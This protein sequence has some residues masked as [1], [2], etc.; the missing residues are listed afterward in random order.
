[1]NQS[2][3]VRTAQLPEPELPLDPLEPDI[4][5]SELPLDEPE[6]DVPAPELPLVPSDPEEPLVLPLGDELPELPVP[7]EPLLPPDESEPEVPL[8]VSEE[9][10]EAPPPEA[11]PDASLPLVVSTLTSSQEHI[12]IVPPLELE[13]DD[14]LPAPDDA[15]LTG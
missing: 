6:P 4:P 8:V 13:L 11:P 7:D 12:I 1:M 3:A 14:V 10:L 5:E 9:P 2:G 15:E